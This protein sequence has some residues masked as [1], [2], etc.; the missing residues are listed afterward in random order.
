MVSERQKYISTSLR[1]SGFAFLTPLASLI[2]QWTVFR[3]DLFL[4]N[5]TYSVLEF[6]A[7]FLFIV[8]GFLVLREK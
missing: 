3:K 2:F 4:G 5:F 6:L 7:G 1:T 8:G